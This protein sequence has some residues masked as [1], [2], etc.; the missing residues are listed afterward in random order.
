MNFCYSQSTGEE[1]NNKPN[2]NHSIEIKTRIWTEPGKRVD[3]F[4]FIQRNRDSV[5]DEPSEDRKGFVEPQNPYF[6]GYKYI[7]KLKRM[8]RWSIVSPEGPNNRHQKRS[9]LVTADEFRVVCLPI[10]M[11]GR[12]NRQDT[13]IPGR[14]GTNQDTPI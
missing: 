7:C 13:I 12:T 14:C 9:L 4:F 10:S 1:Y 3:N 2:F 11:Q 6:W 5:L 8:G